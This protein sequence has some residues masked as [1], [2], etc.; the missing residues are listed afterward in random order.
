[1]G[2]KKAAQ[3]FVVPRKT[4][5]PCVFSRIRISTSVILRCFLVTFILLFLLSLPCFY[6]FSRTSGVSHFDPPSGQN[7]A[8]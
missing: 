5:A 7:G 8:K 6:F 3:K 1:M 4:C 2:Y